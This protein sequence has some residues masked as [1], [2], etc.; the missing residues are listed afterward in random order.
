MQLR[1]LFTYLCVRFPLQTLS[2][3]LMGAGTKFLECVI[4]L[5]H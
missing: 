5:G 4:R 1:I 3:L 2:L